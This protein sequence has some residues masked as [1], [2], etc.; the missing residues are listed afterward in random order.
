MVKLLKPTPLIP[1]AIY[2]IKDPD[3]IERFRVVFSLSDLLDVPLTSMKIIEIQNRYRNLIDE[4]KKQLKVIQSSR[5]NRGNPILKWQLAKK[6][7]D[8]LKYI[9]NNGFYFSNA[10]KSLSRDLGIS[11]R[12]INYLIEF[13]E[14]YGDIGMI[15]KEISWDKY[16]EILDIKD[17]ALQKECVGKILKGELKTREDIRRFKKRLRKI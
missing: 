9:E 11:I 4:C 15:Y 7:K 1:L 2:K 5:K 10:A 12:Q 16:K 3:G 14:T 13:V 8:F 17:K 6:I